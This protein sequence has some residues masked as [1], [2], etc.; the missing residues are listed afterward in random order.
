ML[1]SETAH[2]AEL[3]QGERPLAEDVETGAVSFCPRCGTAAVEPAP[4]V[5]GRC[6][7]RWRAV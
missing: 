6:G 3:A 4:Q 7:A 1:T 5:C 2:L